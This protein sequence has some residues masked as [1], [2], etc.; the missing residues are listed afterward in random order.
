MLGIA[1]SLRSHG[2]D[3]ARSSSSCRL[4]PDRAREK[5][6][7]GLHRHLRPNRR[8]TTSATVTHGRVPPA[9]FGDAGT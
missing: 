5:K 6:T 2:L 8:P 4:G 1:A 3:T 7:C 9:S